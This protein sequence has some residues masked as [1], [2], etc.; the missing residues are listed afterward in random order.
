MSNTSHGRRATVG[1]YDGWLGARYD[2]IVMRPP[3][4]EP[5]GGVSWT[6]GSEVLELKHVDR[7]R[8]AERARL[9]SSLESGVSQNTDFGCFEHF[10][11]MVKEI[12]PGRPLPVSDGTVLPVVQK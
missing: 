11:E 6:L 2:P 4:G 3:G 12:L 10:R 9:L 7:G 1:E 8:V 5:C